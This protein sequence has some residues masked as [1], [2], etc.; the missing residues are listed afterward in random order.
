MPAEGFQ[1]HV[2]TDVSLLGK[3]GK[4][5]ARGGAV[6]GDGALARDVWLDGGRIWRSSAP[7]RGRS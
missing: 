4:W 1:G 6:V 5:G 2:A 7:S 3:A